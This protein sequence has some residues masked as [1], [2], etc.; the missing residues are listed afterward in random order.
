[1]PSG[2]ALTGARNLH[3]FM[4]GEYISNE[5]KEITQEL[6]NHQSTLSIDV[7]GEDVNYHGI[8]PKMRNEPDRETR[9]EA[10]EKCMML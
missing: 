7:D 3:S 9:R 6:M 2:L 8:V 5:T 4:I 1:M 10:F